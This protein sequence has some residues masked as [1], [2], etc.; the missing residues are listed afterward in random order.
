MPYIDKDPDNE[1]ILAELLLSTYFPDVKEWSAEYGSFFSR[2]YSG[3]LLSVHQQMNTVSVSR[4][5][6]YDILPEK[7][8]FDVDELRFKEPRE[9]A[10]LITEIYEMEKNIKD[11]FQPFDSYFFN[12]SMRLRKVVWHMIDNKT[13]LLLKTLFDYH[14]EN[15]ENPY[16]KQLAPLLLNVTEFRGDFSILAPVLSVILDCQVEYKFPHQDEVLFTVHKEGLSSKEYN[17]FMKELKPLF[18]FIQYWFVPMEMDCLYKV[19]DY[20]QRFILS[21]ERALVLDYNTQI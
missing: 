11:Y 2:N 3:D 12:Q 17:T 18:D 13:E 1:K 16:V 15:E 19:K 10:A 14:I 5:G 21:N 4:N 7:M 20:N 6:I 9:F 8:F